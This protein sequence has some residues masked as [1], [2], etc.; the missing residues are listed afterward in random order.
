[1]S[2]AA[3]R[4][5]AAHQDG[6]VGERRRGTKAKRERMRLRALWSDPDREE[7]FRAVM[8]GLRRSHA[9]PGIHGLEQRI[10]SVAARIKEE[11]PL[12]P[13]SVAGARS[14]RAYADASAAILTEEL[15]KGSDQDAPVD[16]E[17]TILAFFREGVDGYEQ[18]G[19]GGGRNMK[20]S[21]GELPVPNYLHPFLVAAHWPLVPPAWRKP[22]I[23]GGIGHD[24]I[25][26]TKRDEEYVGR[27]LSRLL[28]DEAERRAVRFVIGM[29]TRRHI[30]YGGDIEK[31]LI[32][33]CDGEEMLPD[34][35]GL[36]AA[37]K[38]ADWTVNTMTTG[39]IPLFSALKTL[40]KGIYGGDRVGRGLRSTHFYPSIDP[41]LRDSLEFLTRR[42]FLATAMA[43]R[44]R[45]DRLLEEGAPG[46]PSANVAIYEQLRPAVYAYAR[47]N[48]FES[49]SEPVA[50]A[51]PFSPESVHGTG[52]Y[53]FSQLIPRE[54]TFNHEQRRRKVSK[55][56][57]WASIAFTMLGVLFS[58]EEFERERFSD[59]YRKAMAYR[60]EYVRLREDPVFTIR[61]LLT[62]EK[63]AERYTFD[64]SFGIIRRERQER[65]EERGPAGKGQ[66]TGTMYLTTK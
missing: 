24:W 66:T 31:M 58:P 5:V 33:V 35:T 21:T 14:R 55:E 40:P 28:P 49:L 9:L 11:A 57:L 2:V 23:L 29:L 34:E 32:G 43:A 13:D 46:N 17:G 37:S 47:A 6:P 45:I 54:Q 50:D 12:R 27:Y 4:S 7:E 18:Y 51:D 62:L 3:Q 1:M 42:L 64:D 10:R 30:L 53:L 8:E 56:S 26:D 44:H 16:A 63:W 19:K 15:L 60:A 36:V 22:F 65:Q 25:E 48:G 41:S 59:L 39:S 61:T 52:A 38:M 20:L